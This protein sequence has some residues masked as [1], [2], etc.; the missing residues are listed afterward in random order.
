MSKI[1]NPWP[2]VNMPGMDKRQHILQSALRVFARYGVKRTTMSDIAQEAG[3]VRQTLYNAF[4]SKDAVLCAVIR[5]VADDSIVRTRDG[6]AAASSFEDRLD[7]FFRIL[8]EEVFEMLHKA[9]DYEDLASG[10][11]ETG[12]E[13]VDRADRLKA[14]LLAELF[15]PYEHALNAV[16]QSVA[17]YADFVHR[18]AA[19]MKHTA[20]D[21]AEL[22][23]LVASLKASIRAVIT[24][25]RTPGS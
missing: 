7:V 1:D 16:G 17:D 14:A 8:V 24:P 20:R 10:F 2:F 6:W 4:P 3:I 25:D 12:R 13:E 21:Q 11:N 15:D 9:P 18:A 22:S 23:R 5:H 19:H